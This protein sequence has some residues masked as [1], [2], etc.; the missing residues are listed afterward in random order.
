MVRQCSFAGRQAAMKR[1]SV[2]LK[3]KKS[4]SKTSS[5]K[6]EH[7]QN[8]HRNKMIDLQGLFAFIW[9]E[10]YNL[11][12]DMSSLHTALIPH[13]GQCNLNVT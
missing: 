3:V 9:A 1:K 4:Q 7:K 11:L 13:F 6:L 2:L 8:C 12:I 5:C 10:M